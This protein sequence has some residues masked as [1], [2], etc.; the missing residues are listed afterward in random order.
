MQIPVTKAQFCIWSVEKISP[1][2]M[3]I[4]NN[5]VCEGWL[6]TNPYMFSFGGIDSSLIWSGITQ[7]TFRYNIYSD[8]W[9]TIPAL[10]DTLGKIASVASRIKDTIYIIGG[11][12]VLQNGN[13]ISSNKVHRYVI[14]TNTY[15]TDGASIP[16]PI[17]DQVQAVWKDSLIFV[18]T[19][20]SNT[21]NVA[22]VQIY[23][24]YTNTW[25][26]GTPVP[27]TGNYKVFGGTGTIVGDTIY[28]YGGASTGFNF[29]ATNSFRKGYI[30]PLNPTSINWLPALSV[31]GTPGYRYAAIRGNV[32][33]NN[34]GLRPVTFIGGAGTSYN[35]NAIAY[36]GSGIVAPSN[37]IV[38]YDYGINTIFSSP[39]VLDTCPNFASTRLSMDHR[40]VAEFGE[41]ISTFSGSG[42]YVYMCGGIDTNQQVT[43]A[44]YLIL[45]QF[46]TVAETSSS[47]SLSVYP[48]PAD[49]QVTI[50]LNGV[51]TQL[52]LIDLT[53]RVVWTSF[54]SAFAAT[55][56]SENLAEGIYILSIQSEFGIRNSR[57]LIQH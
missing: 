9:D 13:E 34:G 27:G 54:S 18:V 36:N 15:L 48:N 14:P 52:K 31:T 56:N 37:Q 20:W 30:D 55:I 32:S 28:Y 45:S 26:T 29:P 42:Y 1:M 16:I 46:E 22:D 51:P 38:T 19:G 5:A 25:V 3:K 39:T 44:T 2:P 41:G 21:T 8:I 17:D 7:K 53:G 49:E 33:V 43:D 57:I 35:Y 47:S 23:N 11:Y 40:G 6:G 12:H 10:P 24:P 50:E 4:T